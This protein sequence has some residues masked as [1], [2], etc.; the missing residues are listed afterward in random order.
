M[1][2]QS[3]GTDCIYYAMILTVSI[4]IGAIITIGSILVGWT[5]NCCLIDAKPFVQICR[6]LTLSNLLL[7]FHSIIIWAHQKIHSAYETTNAQWEFPAF[8]LSCG[9]VCWISMFCTVSPGFRS[10]SV[11]FWH[12]ILVSL[13]PKPHHLLHASRATLPRYPVSMRVTHFCQFYVTVMHRW[14]LI[15]IYLSDRAIE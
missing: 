15:I 11:H 9:I 4:A 14:S 10:V 1:K 6:I 13:R 8:L 12:K 5:A 3:V 2:T 7:V